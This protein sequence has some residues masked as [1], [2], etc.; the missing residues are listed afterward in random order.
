[1][2]INFLNDNIKEFSKN[3][4]FS[5]LCEKNMNLKLSVKKKERVDNE[6]LIIPKFHQYD[7]ILNYN[8]NLSQL[9]TLAKYYKI[10]LSGNKS[11]LSTRIY[12]FLY[13]SNNVLKIQKVIKGFIQRKYNNC[14]GPAFKKRSLCTNN[15]DFLSMEEVKDIPNSQF[16][17]YEDGGFIYGF[18]ILSFHNLI[19]KSNGIIKNPFNTK[20][21]NQ[22]VI[23]DFNLLIRLSNVLKIKICI[24]LEDIN[25]DLSNKKSIE[26]RTLSLFQ[27]IDA[28]GNYS[29]S[30]WFLSL[31]KLQLIKMV[32]ELK[33]I[34]TFRAHINFDIKMAICPPSGNPFNN[35]NY[36]NLHIMENID[37]V[38]KSILDVLEK[39]ILNGVDK[40]SKC[41]GAYY[42]LGALTLVSIEASISLPWLYQA[43]N[44]F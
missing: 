22:K 29:N 36:N 30:S 26:L 7:M 9:K 11:Q 19:C 42:V 21:I 35:L 33:D 34:W 16:F 14:H 24:N 25:K 4:Y 2:V 3:D 15:Y 20:K 38:R 1:M 6:N 12:S 5:Y 27:N 13:L 8:F 28:L 10:K 18:D 40:D 41:L 32:R 23:E 44:Y 17:S 39:F 43:F 31:N 37:D